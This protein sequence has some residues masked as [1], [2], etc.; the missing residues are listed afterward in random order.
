MPPVRLKFAVPGSERPHTHA[1]DRAATGIGLLLNIMTY[2]CIK[3]SMNTL[4]TLQG[5][6]VHVS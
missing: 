3:V 4:F 1:L 5:R 6:F 2:K